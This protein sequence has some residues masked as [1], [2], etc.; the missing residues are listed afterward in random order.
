MDKWSSRGLVISISS[1][2]RAPSHSTCPPEETATA[3]MRSV[4]EIA[5]HCS[6]LVSGRKRPA[7]GAVTLASRTAD[8]AATL[9]TPVNKGGQPLTRRS[10]SMGCT[11]SRPFPISRP[12]PDALTPTNRLRLLVSWLDPAVLVT[13]CSGRGSGVLEA[14]YSGDEGSSI[15]DSF[16]W[17]Q[18]CRTPSVSG[19][20]RQSSHV[21]WAWHRRPSRRRA[22][23]HALDEKCAREPK[24]FAS[25]RFS[26]N[27]VIL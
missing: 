11:R 10:H 16:S 15:A 20:N 4:F 8:R 21:G 1:S 27:E 25:D 14:G 24:A 22:K 9:R 23:H 3:T 26:R 17:I 2:S 7:W 5:R 6:R 19:N 12:S 13:S 18:G